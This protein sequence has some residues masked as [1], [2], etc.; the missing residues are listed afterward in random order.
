MPNILAEMTR[1][2]GRKH[3]DTRSA[4]ELV[5]F[6][7]NVYQHYKDNCFVLPV[8]I[9]QMLFNDFVFLGYFPD[10]VMEVYQVIT[11]HGW[12]KSKDDIKSV[13]IKK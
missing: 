8:P 7:R 10:L 1:G 12:D 4:V 6:I 11:T 2:R 9:E 13:M 5:R 3:Y